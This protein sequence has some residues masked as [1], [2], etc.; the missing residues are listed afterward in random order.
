[1]LSYQNMANNINDHNR[2][3]LLLSIMDCEESN[4]VFRAAYKVWTSFRRLTIADV[5]RIGEGLV[6]YS[7]DNDLIAGFC[8]ANYA[9]YLAV[10]HY[11]ITDVIFTRSASNVGWIFCYLDSPLN[12]ECHQIPLLQYDNIKHSIY[13]NYFCRG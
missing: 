11:S 9:R 5:V 3:E 8:A 7:P 10:R 6:T 2:Y 13:G 12:V 1:M 4:I